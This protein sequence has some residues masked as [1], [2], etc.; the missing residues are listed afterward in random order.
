MCAKRNFCIECNF[1]LALRLNHYGMIKYLHSTSSSACSA[2]CSHTGPYKWGSCASDANFFG[3][4]CQALIVSQF[5]TPNANAHCTEC[6]AALRCRALTAQ[7]LHANWATGS[8][9]KLLARSLHR[10]SG[11][12]GLIDCPLDN[13]AWLHM[14]ATHPTRAA[15]HIVVVRATL[16]CPQRLSCWCHGLG[17]CRAVFCA[18]HG[19][20]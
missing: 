9:R 1:S 4:T 16:A 3:D 18:Q 5:A 15:I 10:S 6:M 11:L 2:G 19:C 12:E 14:R 13:P 7:L 8:N 17:C 20:W